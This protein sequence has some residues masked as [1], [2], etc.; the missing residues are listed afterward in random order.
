MSPSLP[1]A[2]LC[3][4]LCTLPAR[5]QEVAAPDKLWQS[6]EKAAAFFRPQAGAAAQSLH[7]QGEVVAGAGFGEKLKGAKF[8]LRMEPPRYL[9]LDLTAA[10]RHVVLCQADDKVWIHVP[11][12]KMLIMGDPAAPRF[13]GRADSAQPVVMSLFPPPFS[14]AKLMVVPAL[15]NAVSTTTA[16][17]ARQITLTPSPAAAALEMPMKNPKLTATL[18]S[19]SPWPETLDYEDASNRL[20]LR[21]APTE[22]TAAQPAATWQP[23]PAAGDHVET[24][25]L[26]HLQRF[27][28]V[29]LDSL[30]SRIAT[31]PPVK[32]ERWLVGTAGAGRLE[33]HDGTRVLFLSGTP[34]EMGRQHGTLLKKEI[35]RVVDRILYGVGVG[36][37]FEKGRW[38]FGEVDEAVRRTGPFIDPRHLKEMDAIAEAAG[39]DAEEVH[40]AN[41]FPELF[42]CS[43]FALMGK[44]TADGKL[45]H[46]RILDYLRGAGLEENAVVIVSRPDKG[47]A[48]V[49]ISYAGFTGSVTA[50]N[51][52]QLCIGE[53]G[54][55]G[56]GHWDG[57]P[58]AQ[59]VREVMEKC[60]TVDEAIDFMRR[61]PRTCEYYYVISDAKSH[62]AAG[63]KATPEIFEVVWSGES[64]PQLLDPVQDTVLMSAGSRYEELVKRVK[65]GFGGFDAGKSIQL[66]SRPVCMTSN[67]HSVLFAPDSLDFYVAN[68]DSN[69]VAS[70]T[71]F[72]A[73]NL[74]T[75]LE[76]APAS[77][78]PKP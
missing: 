61:T 58:M 60:S 66:M 54:G 6:L 11:D 70:E 13:S 1:A 23:Q 10:G 48:W 40:L 50:M 5:A 15:V 69:N 41:F 31:L 18:G 65:N 71:R 62:R 30:G 8:D 76:S 28:Q 43:G 73:Y 12:K 47:N 55:K 56:E 37:S 29:T 14:R 32:G 51:E 35:R 74:K 53:M 17:G 59:L 77:P 68:A 78:R 42:H 20:T 21:L 2:A 67:I 4:T 22:L 63:I 26:V 3:L 7:L 72:T 25:A 27:F 57:K 46:G 24:V 34:E 9:K 39:L 49:N 36:S 16:S 44:A 52:K 64:H 19:G 38:F 75:L 45:Y 33:D